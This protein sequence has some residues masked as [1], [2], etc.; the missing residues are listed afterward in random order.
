MTE[1]LRS[2]GLNLDYELAR[3]SAKSGTRVSINKEARQFFLDFACSTG[4]IWS[5]NFRDLTGAITRMATLAPRGRITRQEVKTEIHGLR[6]RWQG[7]SP[8]SHAK[9]LQNILVPERLAQLDRFDQAQLAEVVKIC[10]Q[11]T[12]IS[13]AGRILFN[14]SRQKKKQA[15]DSDR[16]RKY[17]AKFGLD[18]QKVRLCSL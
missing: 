14:V 3:F 5:A 15:N 7:K 13:A 2:G 10:Q 8:A 11:A 1:S 12:S 9:I 6:L 17:L 4:A 16:L 18:W